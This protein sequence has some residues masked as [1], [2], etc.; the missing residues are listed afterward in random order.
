MYETHNVSVIR[1]RAPTRVHPSKS[2]KN[3]A[4]RHVPIAVQTLLK[5]FYYVCLGGLVWAA[6]RGKAHIELRL[7]LTGAVDLGKFGGNLI[8]D[9]GIRT[10][11][12][13]STGNQGCALIP[14]RVSG[15]GFRVS[16]FRQRSYS[17]ASYEIAFKVELHMF[18]PRVHL[19][20]PPTPWISSPTNVTRNRMSIEGVCPPEG[21]A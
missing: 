6:A 8:A 15:F 21:C 5:G 19:L 2:T 20:A 17:T 13:Y 11:R 10:L 9:S 4:G 3:S 16:D 7:W 18:K 12:P 1:W 14:C